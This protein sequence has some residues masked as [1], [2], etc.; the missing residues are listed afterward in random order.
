MVQRE[1]KRMTVICCRTLCFGETTITL[2]G[3][4]R[5]S[6]DTLWTAF[7]TL[8]DRPGMGWAPA[9]RAVFP[10]LSYGP[11]F[12]PFMTHL[13]CDTNCVKNGIDFG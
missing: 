11:S 8:A 5:V 13:H 9:G 2:Y 7:P 10:L 3:N 4:L 6:N 12:D 1:K